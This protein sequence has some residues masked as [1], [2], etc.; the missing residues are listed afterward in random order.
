MAGKSKTTTMTRRGVIYRIE[1]GADGTFG[2]FVAV[3]KATKVTGKKEAGA[4]K[5][6]AKKATSTKKAGKVKAKGKGSARTSK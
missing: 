3:G 4:K 6:E 2:R 1:R 5:D